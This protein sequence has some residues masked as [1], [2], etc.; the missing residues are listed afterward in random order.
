VA[1][2]AQCGRENPG[3][4]RFCNGCGAELAAARGADSREVR[5]VV[6]V[7][8][9]DMA[10]STAFADRADPEAV[11]AVLARY[12]ARM[13]DVIERHGG[14][15]EKFIGDAVMA[16]FGIPHVHED[17]ALRATRAAIEMRDELARLE[18]PARIGVNTG[19]V[20]A[21]P[22]DSLVTG[23][24][25]NVAARLQQSA[26]IGQVLIGDATHALIRDVVIATR[27][28]PLQVKGKVEALAAWDLVSVGAGTRGVRR[29]HDV[30]LIG[31]RSELRLLLEYVARSEEE[32]RG[33]LVTLLGD[34]GVGKSRLVLELAAS[35]DSRVLTGQCLPYGQ[36]IAYRPVADMVRSLDG[37]GSA[38]GLAQLLE[39][40][41]DAGL[42]A[43][44]VARAIGADPGPAE[45]EEIGWGIRRMFEVLARDQPT[46]CVFEDVHWAE[47]A[48][49]DVIDNVALWSRNAPLVVIATARR[50]LLVE[51]P[52]WSGGR[53][54]ATTILLEPLTDEAAS[55]LIDVLPGGHALPDQDRSRLIATAEGNPLFIEQLLRFSAD[56]EVPPTITA[57]M[58]ARV[59]QLSG[60]A[61]QVISCAAVEGRVFH[62]AALLELLPE[63]DPGNV[64]DCLAELI[65]QELIDWDAAPGA[66]QATYRFRHQL[67]RD[68]AYLGSS[69]RGR[70]ER[71][72]ML[73]DWLQSAAGSVDVAVVAHH[74][75]EAVR[76]G[77]ELGDP[78]NKIAPLASRAASFYREAA[79]VAVGRDELI[80]AMAL[81]KRVVEILPAGDSRAVV[82]AA[83]RAIFTRRVL[84]NEVENAV[85]LLQETA[86][87]AE[88]RFRQFADV[89]AR[90]APLEGPN[91]DPADIQ[92]T[93]Q[94][95]DT[96]PD[97]SIAGRLWRIAADTLI[98]VA[99]QTGAG[100]IAATR[101]LELACRSG[102]T[103]LI[104]D[105]TEALMDATMQG[106]GRIDELLQAGENL[107]GASARTLLAAHYL[108]ERCL[109][110]AEMGDIDASLEAITYAGA[111]WREFG[112]ES[113]LDLPWRT[114][115]AYARA[116]LPDLAV[117]PL[118]QALAMSI[119]EESTGLASTIAGE[120]ARAL[121]ITDRYSEARS[122]AER[123]RSYTEDDDLTS[124]LYW[125]GA[126]VRVLAAAGEA[127]AVRLLVDELEALATTIDAPTDRFHAFVD[128]GEAAWVI[129]DEVAGR[130]L[131]EAARHESEERG[132][133]AFVEQVARRLPH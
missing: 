75:G 48:L 116:G 39:P 25:V 93:A 102:L 127:D 12:H 22:G 58:A 113:N 122:E 83:D 50:D 31:R 62:R 35:T 74:V 82:A 117:A 114:G 90:S 110:L 130:R 108:R 59:D 84:A 126:M 4:A 77:H 61:R 95:F 19:E 73:A 29:S 10:A 30:P 32:R 36:G 86:A 68:A 66:N 118:Q 69:K 79:D 87:T 64:D 14:T 15:V 70:C 89:C 17:D 3:D 128:A 5:K 47:A 76:Y 49:L 105:A 46:V 34:A 55:E 124:Q 13:R 80:A 57:L 1:V 115:T 21:H 2:C 40:D 33:Q 121:A 103:W 6:T 18:I 123:A 65:R 129:G 44:R 71:H 112:N 54:N 11:R 106:P 16:V 42:I 120:L 125:R 85:N 78:P 92:A 72:Q 111:I 94:M 109:L 8:F 52:Q 91:I 7:L 97:P 41:Q 23:D 99:R 100:R 20:V 51:R 45:A 133:T 43:E 107:A 63:D 67:I 96:D 38:S 26:A 88:P 56:D 37:D 81:L 98:D 9:C 131:L 132:A 119:V 60:L 104:H 101:S 28:D 53:V 27:V 24:T